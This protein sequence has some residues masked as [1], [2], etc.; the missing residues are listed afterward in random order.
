[1]LEMDQLWKYLNFVSDFLDHCDFVNIEI[2]LL[3]SKF[4]STPK[5]CKTASSV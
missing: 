1:M 2:F 3:M 5:N 4:I